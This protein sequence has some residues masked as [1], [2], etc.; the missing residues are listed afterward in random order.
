MAS[1]ETITVYV[2]PLDIEMVVEVAGVYT[3]A[4]PGR[5]SGPPELCYPDEPEE[6]ECRP[7]LGTWEAALLATLHDLYPDMIENIAKQAEE[8]FKEAVLK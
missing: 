5:Y 8:K 7:T 4:T 3:P 1:I 6:V 2:Q